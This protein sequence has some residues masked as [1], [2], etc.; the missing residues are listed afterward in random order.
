MDVR[1]Y[2]KFFLFIVCFLFSLFS[3]IIFISS[4]SAAYIV[5]LLFMNPLPHAFVMLSFESFYPLNQNT[6]LLKTSCDTETE[7]NSDVES[8]AIIPILP[9]L[10]ENLNRCL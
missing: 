8:S 6:I 9:Q 5:T 7:R 4:A 2:S 3:S 1:F 10:Q